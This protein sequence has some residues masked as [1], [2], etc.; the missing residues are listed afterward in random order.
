MGLIDSV[1]DAVWKLVSRRYEYA[2]I[3]AG[4][5]ESEILYEGEARIHLNGWVETEDGDQ[6]S[7]N[8]VHHIENQTFP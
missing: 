6:F 5:D 7:P 3:Y 2:A 4:P 1:R 8:A